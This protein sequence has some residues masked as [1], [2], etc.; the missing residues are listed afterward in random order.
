MSEGVA[1]TVSV[2]IPFTVKA[3]VCQRDSQGETET[4]RVH[5]YVFILF[6]TTYSTPLIPGN[7]PLLLAAQMDYCDVVSSLVNHCKA[8]LQMTV[9]TLYMY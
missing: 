3:E 4:R 6:V 8:S 7:T 1:S 9:G 5:M 2:L